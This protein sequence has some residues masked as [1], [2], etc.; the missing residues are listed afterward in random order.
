[1]LL[2]GGGGSGVISLAFMD[3]YLCTLI[4]LGVAVAD[5]EEENWENQCFATNFL[6]GFLNV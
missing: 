5:M 1:M 3:T 2:L 4:R 6:W